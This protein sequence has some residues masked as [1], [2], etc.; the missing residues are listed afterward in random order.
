MTGRTHAMVGMAATLVLYPGTLPN[1]EYLQT[2]VTTLSGLEST[3][4][5][6]VP[7]VMWLITAR[8]ASF[9]PDM[10]QPGSVA[11]RMVAGPFGKSRFAALLGSIIFLYFGAYRPPAFI[12]VQY[13]ET[14]MLVLTGIGVMLFIMAII[15]HRG[16]THSIPGTILVYYGFNG[17]MHLPFCLKYLNYDLVMPFMIGYVVGHLVLDLCADEGIAPFYIPFVTKTH[18]LYHIP[19]FIRT[20]SILDTVVIRYSAFFFMAYTVL[21]PILT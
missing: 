6:L 1:A 11:P 4:K 20:E 13:K 12:P 7:L 2:H 21:K 8:V 3:V 5:L 17:L 18:K 16:I 10:D 15:K 14:V 19:T 9:S